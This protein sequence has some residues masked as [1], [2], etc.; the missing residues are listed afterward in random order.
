MADE[1]RRRGAASARTPWR[2]QLDSYLAHHRRSA[3]DSGRRLRDAPLTSLMTGLVI[4]I[5]LAL[6]VGLLL[7]LASLQGVSADWDE[8]ARI[9][10]FIEEGVESAAVEALRD[11]W[12]DESAIRSVEWI[13]Q[14]QALSQFRERSGMG[15]ALDFF[16]DDNPLPHTLILTPERRYQQAG[17]LEQL[18]QRLQGNDI[19]ARVQVDLEWLQRLNAIADVLKR[20]VSAIAALL[21]VGVVLV[22]GNTIR[23]AIENR[24]REIIVAKLV[25][26]TEAF[27]RRPFLYTGL[28]YG[29]LGGLLAWW[30]VEVAMWWLS[31]PVGQLAQ[32]YD[33]SFGL[34]RLGFGDVLLLLGSAMLLG[35]LGAWVAVKRHLDA[36]EPR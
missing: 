20:G 3:R 2:D 6:P 9:S 22:I 33:S 11:D 16:E 24:R 31:G 30:I 29:A 1:P 27:V 25:G 17:S 32:L 7:I 35:W 21:I 26:G 12:Q 34:E 5:A 36:I 15:Q 23:L 18:S 8:A 19:V 10:V 13:D 14:E 28:W 4:A